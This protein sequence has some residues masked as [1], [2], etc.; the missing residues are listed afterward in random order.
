MAKLTRDI[1]RGYFKHMSKVYDT[2]YV[3]KQSDPNM[4]AIAF[5]L[6][7]MRIMDDEVFLENYAITICSPRRR[8]IYLPFK[9]GGRAVPL[10]QQIELCTHEH[11]HVR[12]YDRLGVGHQTKYLFDADYRAHKEVRALRCN[13]EMH[14]KLTKRV[15]NPHLLAQSLKAYRLSNAQIR[16][17]QKHLEEAARVVAQGGIHNHPS[18]V[19]WRWLKK[20]G[21]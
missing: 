6:D 4:K 1:T 12:Q 17:V 21:F 3:H 13:M 8:L 11:H 19:G 18:K 20:Q 10:L 2:T 14:Y 9:P 16:V 7:L 5:A 15:L